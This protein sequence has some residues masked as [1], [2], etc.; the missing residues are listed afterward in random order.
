MSKRVSSV[1]FDKCEQPEEPRAKP[2][3]KETEMLWLMMTFGFQ[4]D[5]E[6]QEALEHPDRLNAWKGGDL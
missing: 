3:V 1:R 4:M 6:L 5:S 2:G